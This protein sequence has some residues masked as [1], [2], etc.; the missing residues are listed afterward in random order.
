MALSVLCSEMRQGL[1]PD[2]KL[3]C[4]PHLFISSRKDG[5]HCRKLPLDSSTV[6]WKADP[7]KDSGGTPSF[8]KSPLRPGV[9]IGATWVLGL[10]G[11]E[12]PAWP[13][14]QLVAAALSRRPFQSG[15]CPRAPA[16]TV[17]LCEPW[18][19]RRA[20]SAPS[21][22]GRRRRAGRAAAARGN[23]R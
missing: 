8:H 4:G 2:E 6:S 20:V 13:G 21:H 22:T 9:R 14:P 1:G 7:E 15:P 5:E 11:R 10:E 16:G 23:A 12:S 17:V 19:S 18:R 3:R